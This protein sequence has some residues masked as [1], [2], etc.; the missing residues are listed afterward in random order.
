MLCR[1]VRDET[2]KSWTVWTLGGVAYALAFFQRTAPQAMLDQLMSDFAVGATGVAAV[3]STY[4]IS[5]MVMQLP[6]G[7]WLIALARA[8]R[9]RSVLAQAL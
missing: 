7:S 1:S 4:F 2:F 5:Y 9:W 8:A 3:T 6:G